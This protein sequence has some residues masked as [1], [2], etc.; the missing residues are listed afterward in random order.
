MT[1]ARLGEDIAPSAV[2]QASVIAVFF[3]RTLILMLQR[4]RADAGLPSPR[5]TS[6]V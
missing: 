2:A 1:P 3:K 5:A 4:F 6:L